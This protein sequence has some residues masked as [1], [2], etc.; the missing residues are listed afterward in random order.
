[1]D[2]GREPW[3]CGYGR[4]LMFERLWVR[5]PAPYGQ[6]IFSHWFVVKIV[7]F[8]WKDEKF[9]KKWPGLAHLKKLTSL[10]C[11]PVHPVSSASARTC[12]GRWS[13]NRRS[14]PD[15]QTPTLNF[16]ASESRFLTP[17]CSRV[18]HVSRGWLDAR[19]QNVSRVQKL[20]QFSRMIS[21]TTTTL[22]L[23]TTDSSWSLCLDSHDH[24][25]ILPGKINALVTFF[26]M[27]HLCLKSKWSTIMEIKDNTLRRIWHWFCPVD[28]RTGIRVKA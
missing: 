15:I 24:S 6:D 5:I 28:G 2:Q 10:L 18:W 9:T 21:T 22:Q 23:T 26:Y 1:M 27:W 12:T 13:R 16:P 11:L 4:R 25:A 17:A 14:G 8:V 20:W 3:S 19:K 7:L